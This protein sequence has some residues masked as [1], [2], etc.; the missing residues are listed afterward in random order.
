[1]FQNGHDCKLKNNNAF[2]I[3]LLVCEFYPQK[4]RSV[5]SVTLR[6]ISTRSYFDNNSGKLLVFITLAVDN[7]PRISNKRF[8]CYRLKAK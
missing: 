1:M 4:T 3:I 5:A 6:L 2:S 8:Y 7:L